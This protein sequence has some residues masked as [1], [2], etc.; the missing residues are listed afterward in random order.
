VSIWGA[1]A[2]WKNT[3][4]GKRSYGKTKISIECWYSLAFLFHCLSSFTLTFSFALFIAMSK[5]MIVRKT[6]VSAFFRINTIL[7]S[8]ITLWRRCLP[9][10]NAAFG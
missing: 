3:N 1:V 2:A 5:T 7:L 10:N 6:N 8:E 9:F 4:I